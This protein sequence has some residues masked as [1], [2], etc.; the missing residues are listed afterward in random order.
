[1]ASCQ[2]RLSPI[3]KAKDTTHALLR[4]WSWRAICEMGSPYDS[5]QYSLVLNNNKGDAF[6]SRSGK[7]Y[8]LNCL[9]RDKTDHIMSSRLDNST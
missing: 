6:L 4:P 8:P 9:R 7:V 3:L 5:T 1:M 2:L